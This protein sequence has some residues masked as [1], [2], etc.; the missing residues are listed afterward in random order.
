M[1]DECG[2]EEQL[3]KEEEETAVFNTA[4]SSAGVPSWGGMEDEQLAKEDAEKAVINSV[5]S[6]A[7]VT[8]W[9]DLEDECKE[10][11]E[12]LAQEDA[13]KAVF[14]AAPSTAGV[15]SWADALRHWQ[16][17]L[18][19]HG[20]REQRGGVDGGAGG[21]WH[22]GGRTIGGCSGET[23]IAD[24]MEADCVSECSLH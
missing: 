6:T 24:S 14:N 12:R 23:S 19:R 22:N 20:G 15:D 21:C 17:L 11:E 13:E 18:R 9:A 5:P 4:P 16:D 10:E 8:T 3:A 2:K 1:E 7:G